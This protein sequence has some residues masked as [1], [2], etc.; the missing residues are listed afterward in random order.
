LKKLEYLRSPSG[1][2]N[3]PLAPIV[4]PVAAEQ[5][6]VEKSSGVGVGFEELVA[7]GRGL[8]LLGRDKGW[9][10]RQAEQNPG[11]TKTYATKLEIR[12]CSRD[13]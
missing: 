8:W 3:N 1:Y 2:Y 4:L 13:K 10:W 6:L 7:S 12:G 5:P 9:W 11:F